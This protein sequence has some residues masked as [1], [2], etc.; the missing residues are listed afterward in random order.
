MIAI[1][2]AVVGLIVGFGANTVIT[3]KRLGSAE[4][5]ANKELERAK[6]EA[7]KMIDQ[8]REE[9]AKAVEQ[10]RKEELARRN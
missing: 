10:T 6:K 7:N 5:K 4:E 9:S 3:K 8:A 1:L 2:L